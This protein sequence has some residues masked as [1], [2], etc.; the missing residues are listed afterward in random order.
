MGAGCENMTAIRIQK[1]LSE[2][3]VASRRAVE[4]MVL[5]GRIAVN[6]RVVDELPCFVDP[7]V[8][9]VVADGRRV[10]LGRAPARRIYFLL[11]KPRGVVCTQSDP[12]GRPK[13]VDLV[14]AMS[15]SRVYCVGRLDV[16]STGLILLTN[17]GEL[18]QYLTHPRYGVPKTY[19]VE[20]DGLLTG[21]QIAA[22]K[23]GVYLDGKRTG[24]AALK[25][26]RKS[27]RRSL[28]EITLT[29]GRNRELRRALLQFGAKVNRLKRVSIGPVTDRGLKIGNFRELRPSELTALRKSGSPHPDRRGGPA[30]RAKRKA[31]PPAKPKRNPRGDR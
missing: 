11:N 2:A 16:D 1:L 31:R 12:Q 3:G 25:V 5:D 20:I 8:D 15:G 23:R 6:G 26:L 18:T 24:G 9:R 21:E 7:E 30:K 17:D 19:V 27:P 28:L 29:E 22:F 14:P 13:A 4:Q 10:R